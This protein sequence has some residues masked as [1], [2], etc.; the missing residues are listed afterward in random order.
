MVKIKLHKEMRSS[1]NFSV[2]LLVLYL[3]F[4]GSESQRDVNNSTV[5][6]NVGVILDTT[7]FVGNIGLTYLEMAHSDFYS[8]HTSYRTRLVLHVRDSNDQIIDAAAAAVDL[9]K[10][11]KTDAII[12]PQKSSQANI[13]MDLGDRAH[14][15]IISFS[16]TSPSLLRRT[17]YFIQTAQSDDA[18][19]GAIAAVVKYFQWRGVVI[20]HEDTEYGTGVVPHLSNALQDFDVRIMYRS[21]IPLSATDDFILKE[22]YKMMTQQTRVFVVHML[23]N[24]GARLFLKA[25]EI[26]M[27]NEG[28]AWIVTNDMTDSLYSLD[29]HVIEAMQGVLGVKPLIPMSELNMSMFGIWAYN[30]LWALAMSAERIGA[31]K[32]PAEISN[33]GNQTGPELLVLPVSQTGPELLKAMLETSFVEN[34]GNFKL[35]KGQ[36]QPS[37]YKILNVIGNKEKEVG[38]WVPGSIDTNDVSFHDIVWPGKSTVV[39]KGWEFPVS[40]KRLKIAVPFKNG[41]TEFV[42]V[43]VDPKTNR[44]I[45]SGYSI[46]IFDSA[47]RALPYAVPYDYYPFENMTGVNAGSSYY[48]DLVYQVYLQNFD[49]A[50]GDITITAN[51]SKYVDFTLPYAEG[52]ISMIVPITYED[53]NN[54]WIF[55]KPLK[56]ELWLTSIALAIGTGFVVWLLEHRINTAFR[57]PPSHHAGMI[58]Y[59]PCTS[60]V[61]AN[62]EKIVSNLARLVVAVWFI[63]VLLWSSIYSASLSSRLTLQNLKPIVSDVEELKRNGDFVGYEYGSFVANVLKD[64]NF[65]DSKL[66][67]YK[68]RG[69]CHEALSMGTNNGGISAFFGVIPYNKYFVSKYCDKFATI[70][71]IYHTDGNAFP[72]YKMRLFLL[73]KMLMSTLQV[74]PKGSPLVADVSRALIK[75]IEGDKILDLQR[76]W[77]GSATCVGSS[78]GTPSSS[79]LSL[80]SFEGLFIITGTI[81]GLCLVI[82]L[83]KYIIQNRI[84]LVERISDRGSTLWSKIRSL[85][86]NFDGKDF[87]TN[88]VT[89]SLIEITS[90]DQSSNHS[91]NSGSSRRNSNL[92]NVIVSL[93]HDD[94]IDDVNP[95]SQDMVV[96]DLS[97]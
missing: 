55:F 57:G 65:S 43:V 77:F 24:I 84:I 16:A 5:L 71:P 44:K 41:F 66:K 45:V 62:S 47:M 69:E 88:R 87:P 10:N 96:I 74:F 75:V 13:V 51:R 18:Q 92:S 91:Y 23:S 97:T 7:T 29:S 72:I 1:N 60:L 37:A 70:G 67:V 4:S 38:I 12:G 15:P 6:F 94:S 95:N 76:K 31:P 58:L 27:M 50:V 59:F 64:M 93:S 53:M 32:Q 9:L 2:Y 61:F 78:N 82:Y 34:G 30:T 86:V 33:S 25:K 19:V 63:V 28:Y 80:K 40:G 46:D 20:I 73:A 81:S 56:K 21:I 11:V 90:H 39:P 8:T 3:S 52:G 79:N 83:A 49:A 54:K 36:L 26:G 35:D 48:N 14:V 42:K 22:L 85:H 17:P 89:S 68:S